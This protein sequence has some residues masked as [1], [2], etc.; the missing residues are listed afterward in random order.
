M[1]WEPPCFEEI[2]MDAELSSYVD[3]LT[4]DPT[5]VPPADART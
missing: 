1:D 5:T 3:D 4:W 2:K